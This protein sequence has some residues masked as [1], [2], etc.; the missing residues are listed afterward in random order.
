MYMYIN[1][2]YVIYITHNCILWN[3]NNRPVVRKKKYENHVHILK[4]FLIE[5]TCHNVVVKNKLTYMKV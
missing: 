2:A 5:T 1:N 3:I 4:L